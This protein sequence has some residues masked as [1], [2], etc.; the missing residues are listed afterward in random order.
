[1]CT[2]FTTSSESHSILISCKPSSSTYLMASWIPVVSASITVTN[3]GISMFLPLI[4]WPRSSRITIPIAND[5]SP[6]N[7]EASTFSFRQ[8]FWGG[9][10]ISVLCTAD[11]VTKLLRVDF[12]FIA[13][14]HSITC[15]ELISIV[16]AGVMVLP[17]HIFWFLP[18]YHCYSLDDLGLSVL[19]LSNS[20]LGADST[21]CISKRR[22][23]LCQH[24]DANLQSKKMCNICSMSPSHIEYRMV[25]ATP[26]LLS[27]FL[28]GTLLLH[29]LQKKVQPDI[30]TVVLAISGL[31][32]DQNWYPVLTE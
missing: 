28:T 26:L 12:H 15:F 30:R 16:I 9:C 2:S 23:S 4:N 32:D 10:Q 27:N 29:N 21:I 13:S 24:S 3:I 14:C 31:C 20:Q 22:P 7:T 1:M 19:I 8:C 17:S 18:Q 5:D 6:L 25:V 11:L